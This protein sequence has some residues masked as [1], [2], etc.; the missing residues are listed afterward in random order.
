MSWNDQDIDNLFK[1]AKAPEIPP[2]QEEF[3]TEME[4]M[5]PA[6]KKTLEPFVNWDDQDIDDLFKGSNT[7][8]IPP[9]QE[10]FWAEME[11]ILPA[12]KKS[13]KPVI[14]W[15]S[16]I[17]ATL[18]LISGAFWM[19]RSDASRKTTGNTVVTSSQHSLANTPAESVSAS[20]SGQG[21][22][23]DNSDLQTV[24]TT[25]SNENAP[26]GMQP[27]QHSSS[28]ENGSDQQQ[29][30]V[31][32][33]QMPLTPQRTE[34]PKPVIPSA[35][36][37]FTVNK[38]Q[39]L[40]LTYAPIYITRQFKDPVYKPERF[41]VQVSSG[42]GQSPQSNV[43]STSGL[44]H[45]YTLGAGLFKRVDRIVFTYGINGRVDLSRNII[46]REM[47]S[48]T[49]RIDTRYSELYSVETPASFGYEF[50]RN[51][52]VAS[53]T[54]G[55]QVSFSGKQTEFEN[56][57]AVHSK[58]ISGKTENTKTLTMEMGMSYWRTLQ[59]NLY[60][61]MGVNA[62]VIR[63]FSPGNFVGDQRK[64]PF[65]GQIILRKTF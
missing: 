28:P 48:E 37:H 10:E 11:G 3:W 29:P 13:R 17:A 8:G 62:D 31:T 26:V 20:E 47:T 54:P 34:S 53:V 27:R 21:I 23:A 65:N 18:L 56:D 43:G 30:Q 51:A 41:Y 61:G 49:H 40:T 64:L 14:W 7:P 1:G 32:E 46:S 33:R 16:G 4:G 35:E 45:Y 52:F 50:G 24:Q 2:F 55:L 6:Q 38:L 19:G 5:L 60:L 25:S 58:R 15:T 22:S 44:M 36:E 57:V 59:P 9:F 12:Q 42:F 39:P 63:P